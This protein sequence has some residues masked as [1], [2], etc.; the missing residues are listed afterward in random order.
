M[1]NV[2]FLRVEQQMDQLLRESCSPFRNVQGMEASKIS[3]NNTNVYLLFMY[4]MYLLFFLFI[5]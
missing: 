3:G 2:K 5:Y 1:W 4:L